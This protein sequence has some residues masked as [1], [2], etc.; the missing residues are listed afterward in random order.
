LFSKISVGNVPSSKLVTNVWAK[1]ED[2]VIEAIK[3]MGFEVKVIF[4]KLKI[5]NN[6]NL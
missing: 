5:K 3:L 2:Q 6:I 4:K 1:K